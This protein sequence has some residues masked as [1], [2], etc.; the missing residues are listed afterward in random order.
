[1]S[2]VANRVPPAAVDMEQSVLSAM[3]MDN[4][5]IATVR[6]IV[7]D[8]MFFAETHRRVFRAMCTLVDAGVVVDPHT[9]SNQLARTN[10]LE[11]VGGKDFVSYL[12]DAVPTAANVEYHADVVREKAQ[13]RQ[14]IET[15]VKGVQGA[16][17]ESIP[18]QDLATSLQSTLLP[19]AA[20]KR[21]E[22]FVHVKDDVWSMME[23]LEARAAGKFAKAT[24]PVG[25]PEIDEY[26]GG[27]QRAELVFLAGVPGGLKTAAALNM[28]VNVAREAQLGAAIVSAETTRLKL[29]ERAL[30]R[31][32]EVPFGAIRAGKLNESDFRALG[33]AAGELAKLPLW[34]DQSARPSIGSVVA[35]SRRLKEQHPALAL[36]VVDYVQLLTGGSSRR[37]ENR[38]LELSDISYTLQGLA[39]ELDVLCIATCQVDATAIEARTDKRPREGDMR[40]SQAMREAAAWIGLCYRD[41]K[42][43]PNPLSA[44]TLEINFAKAKDAEPFKVFLNWQGQF[45]RLDSAKRRQY[46]DLRQPPTRLV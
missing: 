27:L 14:L 3:M 7:D 31:L 5:T 13:R 45:M 25:F 23:G 46:E 2:D 6:A 9:L 18:V 28:M 12:I 32:S 42:Y 41:Q 21:G 20:D 11:S 37:D 35:K 26:S 17:D 8:S 39:K 10:E 43:N 22:G 24:V 44:D 4:T 16:Y 36:L 15:L 38:S 29:H 34:A 19:L 33:R 30:T 40:W 1:M